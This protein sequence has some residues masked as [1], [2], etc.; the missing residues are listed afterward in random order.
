MQQMRLFGILY[1]SKNIKKIS[2]KVLTNKALLIL[3]SSTLR[4]RCAPNLE[5]DTERITQEKRQMIPNELVWPEE[6]WMR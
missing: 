5:N 6:G 2:K 4:E 1:I 3:L